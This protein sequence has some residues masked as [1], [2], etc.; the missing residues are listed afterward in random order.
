MFRWILVLPILAV[1]VAITGGGV[2][3]QVIAPL[4]M[5]LFRQKYPKWLFDWNLALSRFNVR[6]LA[7]LL[8]VQDEYP[9]TDEEQSVH[10]D[11]PHPDVQNDLN[12][13]MPLVKWFLAFPHYVVW[14]LLAIGAF[15]A[16]IIAWFSILFT[17]RMPRG[18]FDYV[19]GVMRYGI[20]IELYA[21][22]L[23]TDKYPRFSISE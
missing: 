18:L 15:I 6:V 16:V 11:F 23:T 14:T 22:M 13:W 9:S 17:G 12:R 10:L 20:R 7:Y 2:G 4:L 3:I 19:V 1:S 5:I 21:F 8:L